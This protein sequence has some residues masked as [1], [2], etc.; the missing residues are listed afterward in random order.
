MPNWQ[1]IGGVSGMTGQYMGDGVL[2]GAV[3]VVVVGSHPHG[4]FGMKPAGKLGTSELRGEESGLGVRVP[5]LFLQQPDCD[6]YDAAGWWPQLCPA[7]FKASLI[8]QSSPNV[9]FMVPSRSDTNLSMRTCTSA[10]PCATEQ[11]SLGWG[12]S[13]DGPSRA[14]SSAPTASAVMG[15]VSGPGDCG[16]ATSGCG[17]SMIMGDGSLCGIAGGVTS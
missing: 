14:G 11:H 4:A 12:T 8:D 3:V 1:A 7:P 5:S 13:E 17:S 16:G 9:L 6:P 10:L 15:G 2:V